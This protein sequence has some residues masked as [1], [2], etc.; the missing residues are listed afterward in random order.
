VASTLSSPRFV[1]RVGELRR[2]EEGIAAAAAGRP[3]AFAIGGEAGVGKTRLVAALSE[4]AAATGAIVAIGGC[5]DVEDGR[6]PFGPFVQALRSHVGALD[7]AARDELV[8]PSADE[9]A[10]LLPELA[11]TN[12]DPREP[13]GASSQGRLFELV[14]DLLGRLATH[15]PLLLVV[16]DLHWADRS[17][18][19]LLGFV[20]RNLRDERI[21]L[22]A[23]FRSD[24]LYR[25]HPLRPFLAELDRSRRV[26]RLELPPFTRSELADQ[27]D[28]IRGRPAER[29]LVDSILER[30]QG[31][32][33]FAEELL[34]AD[35]EGRELPP[36]LRD[37]L[38]ARVERQPS[39]V[40]DV[41]RA[42]AAGGRAVP[43]G[44][45]EAVSPLPDAGRTRA[46]RDAVT[47][48]LLVH[49]AAEGYAF[50]HA[51]LRE[52]VYE[53]LLPGERN[54]IH[55]AYGEA[56]SARPDLA[57]DV[58]TVTADL[59]RHWYAAH[60]LPR[61]L[62][63]AAEAG[64]SAERRSGFAEART[65]FERAL[66]LWDRVPDAQAR[67]GLT[68]I[69]L[70]RRAAEAANLA[71]D[72]GRA[73]A[74]VRTA[75]ELVDPA[76]DAATAGIV[77]ERLGRY[78][79][80]SGD[81]EA[82]LSA[83]EEAVRIVP[84]D[85][86]SAARARVL[87]AR[88]QGLMLLSRHEESRACCEEAIAIARAVGARA[89]EGHALNTL[90][91][92]LAYLGDTPS[93][94][95]HLVRARE[96][97][98][99]VGDLDDIG[100]AY[101]N[102]S[103]LLAGPLNRLEEA[104]ELAREGIEWARRVGLAGDYGVSLQG[105]A[106]EALLR[107][108]RWD[109]ADGMLRAAEDRHPIEMA[110]ID[111]HHGAAWLHICR[112]AFD[113]ASRH[114]HL[115]RA[116]TAKTVDPQY[117]APLCALE[118]ELALWHGD[119]D[120]ARAAAGAGLDHLAGT[121]DRWFSAPL[122]WLALWAEA[123]AAARPAGRGADGARDLAAAAELLT[124]ARA[125]L[126]M[127]AGGG[128]FVPPGTRGYVLLCEAELDRLA[129]T[130][131]PEPWRRAAAA[132]R[133]LGQPYPEAYARWREGEALVG[134]RRAREGGEALAFAL[135]CADTLGAQPLAR[136]VT[137]LARR[138]RLDLEGRIAAAGPQDAEGSAAA[139]IGLTPRQREVLELV[140]AG[141]TNREIAA[142]LFVT[143]KTAGAHVSSILAKLN[144]RSRVEAAT[145]AHRLGLVASGDE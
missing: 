60:D 54:R 9:L 53:E 8:S 20:V 40:Q 18:R 27:L 116:L 45:L 5:I 69:A 92:D 39:E 144:V 125:L 28:A 50:R 17:T 82:A 138:A 59:A 135:A 49:R 84:A 78:L 114:L 137:L 31:N 46:L 30:S 26:E 90:G 126:D 77:R 115:A 68:R 87:A 99:E 74:L 71:G 29:A 121:D 75:I 48:H 94:I 6:L 65:H 52:A 43:E 61:A 25:G 70:I 63:T 34:A 143:E 104:V 95:A 142:A 110:A 22:V 124:R 4:R 112:G 123:D 47:H 127:P 81:S 132:W 130:G 21:M 56:L 76:A 58:E 36:T 122:L 91:A 72:H 38:L 19:D 32:A 141:R 93:A 86:P 108:G 119:P 51:L 145:A 66:E 44:L 12:G 128:V 57:S 35:S 23:T 67:V 140:A 83:Y 139:G 55:A 131:D 89:E 97:A 105:N 10:R 107:L 3:A 41:L 80:A 133:S 1:G 96:I 62:A 24:E 136:E 42:V 64:R 103:D 98:V 73:A 15:A 79:W 129:R 85:P 113:E 120:A 118:A 14:L 33:F 100:R 16:E 106:A 2:L 111:L 101:L 102:L 134:R 37:I 117:H 13:A 7:R 88:G 109:E 11:P